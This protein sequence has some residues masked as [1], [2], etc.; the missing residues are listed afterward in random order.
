MTSFN[1]TRPARQ[2]KPHIFLLKGIWTY[3]Y[4]DPWKQEQLKSG[5]DMKELNKLGSYISD[6][7]LTRTLNKLNGKQS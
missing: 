1:F 3:V 5:T 6:L 7:N 4:S 2:N